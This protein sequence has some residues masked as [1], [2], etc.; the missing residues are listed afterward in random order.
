MSLRGTKQSRTVQGHSV[1]YEIATLSLAMTK[2]KRNKGS[3][4]KKTWQD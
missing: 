2:F 4:I 3:E 1:Y